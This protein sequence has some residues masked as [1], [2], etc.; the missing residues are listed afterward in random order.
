MSAAAEAVGAVAT[1]RPGR[2]HTVKRRHP[3]IFSGAVA[4]VERET[5]SGGLVRVVSADGEALGLGQWSPASQIRIRMVAFG[6]GAGF[7]CGGRVRAAIA[8]RGALVDAG[9]T[10]AMRL[11]NAEADGLPGVVVDRY[12]DWAVCQFNTAGAAA[13]R[14]DVV[15]ALCGALPLKGVYERADADVLKR[16]GIAGASRLLRGEEPPE[17]LEIFENGVKFLVDVRRGHKTGF[18]LDQRD[19]RAAVKALAAGREVLNVFSYT[20]G[21]GTAAL[22]G[23]A[24]SAVN[25]DVSAPALALAREN[26]V[27][28]GFAPTDADFIEGNAFEV[29]RKFRDAGRT[30]DMVVLDPPKFAES[31]MAVRGAA[32]GYKDI[33][34]LAMKLLRPGGVLATFSCSGAVTPEIFAK[35]VADAAVDSGAGFT[36]MRRLWQ[37]P[38]HAETPFFPEGLYLKGLM[39]ERFGAECTMHEA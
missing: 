31:K 13:V 14:D 34:L 16:E 6:P 23:G 29:L 20:G 30:F 18:Y 25:I 9:A 22:C 26:A 24:A 27:L 2:D 21:F 33:N 12:G 32:R 4:S 1:L 38:D 17:R 28:N 36:I 11:V 39:M 19:N 37:A 10:N 35:I 5:A 7:D 8:R 3:W 15:E